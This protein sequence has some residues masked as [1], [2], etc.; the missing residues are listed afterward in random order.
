MDVIAGHIQLSFNITAPSLPHIQ[1]GKVRAIA[2]TSAQ[3]VAAL[4]GIPTIAESGVP[5]F[6]NSTWSGIGAPAA[7]PPAIVER[8][9]REIGEAMQL[10]D[11]KERFLTE[12]SVPI[13]GTPARF[14]EYLRVEIAKYGKLI[15]QAG[16]KVDQN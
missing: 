12:S 10:S 9:N 15:R 14:R 11:V 7:T 16:I 3:R 8:L 6:E 2:V 1:A 5:G 4:P 13:G